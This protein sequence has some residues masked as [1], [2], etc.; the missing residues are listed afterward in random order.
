MSSSAGIKFSEIQSPN[1]PDKNDEGALNEALSNLDFGK[2]ET[3]GGR[4]RDAWKRELHFE[5]FNTH[6]PP[7]ITSNTRI[8]AVCGI[9]NEDARPEIDGWMLSDFFAFWNIFNSTT[10]HQSWM[11]S[12]DLGK[13][14]EKHQVYLHGNPYKRRKVVL[15][16]SILERSLKSR[17]LLE[18]L[19]PLGFK[20]KVLQRIRGE[21]SKANE[22]K[23]NVL[24]LLFGHGNKDNQGIYLGGAPGSK[25]EMSKLLKLQELTKAITKDSAINITLITM[26][27]YSGGWTCHP[28]VSMTTLTAARA[29]NE[30]LSW[31]ASGFSGRYCGTI[32]ASA[33]IEKMTRYGADKRPLGDANPEQKEEEMSEEQMETYSAFSKSVYET[34][35]KDVERRG[36]EHRMTFGAQDDAWEM[37]WRE[38]TGM[39]LSDYA[40]R[41]HELPNWNE[42]MTLNLGDPQ[43]RDL[44]VTKETREEYARLIDEARKGNA[45]SSNKNAEEGKGSVLGKRK[46]SALFGGSVEGL[47]SVVSKL[48]DEYLACHGPR[49][50]SDIDGGL[51][52]A[53][54][55]IQNGQIQDLDYV[56]WALRAIEYRMNIMVLADKYLKIMDIGAPRGLQC[57][58]YNTNNLRDQIDTREYDKL[59]DM[60]KIHEVLFPEP[61]D[62]Q[63]QPFSKGHDYLIAAFDAAEILPNIVAGKITMLVEIVDA[64]V[65]DKKE[66]VKRDPEIVLKRRKLFHSFGVALRDMSP[67][68]RRSRE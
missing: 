15:D 35:L 66:E 68:K 45:I 19:N 42:D 1:V 53:I 12:L 28:N 59:H 62:D 43:N 63:G 55:L 23:E 32:S 47:I 11:H 49:D 51:Q 6:T 18:Q 16:D 5:K 36:Y 34:V 50:D 33:I 17:H 25:N 27:C 56:E 65:E 48:G 54:N 8:A 24:I 64:E 13:L 58:E 38:R 61:M 31:R 40:K 9:V 41:W 10:K 26:H 4:F 67:V 39:P 30:S 46:T 20:S 29:T 60:L 37:C 7:D 3:F 22:G 21:C 14:V 52:N 44:K 57:W 2:P